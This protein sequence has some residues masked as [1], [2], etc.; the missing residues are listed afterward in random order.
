MVP[1]QPLFFQGISVYCNYSIPKTTSALLVYC[2]ISCYYT[3]HSLLGSWTNNGNCVLRDHSLKKSSVNQSPTMTFVHWL[4]LDLE[5][6]THWTQSERYFLFLHTI[7]K[8]ASQEISSWASEVKFSKILKLISCFF[9]TYKEYHVSVL[10][11]TDGAA[12]QSL[13]SRESSNSAKHEIDS[14]RS[15]DTV[16]VY[17]GLGCRRL[18][19]KPRPHKSDVWKIGTRSCCNIL[20]FHSCYL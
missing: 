5:T 4:T 7:L 14:G 9:A 18:L 10:A 15:N 3:D 19:W 12:C 1:K 2:W 13:H 20:V 8:T 16:V 17:R 6:P 11:I